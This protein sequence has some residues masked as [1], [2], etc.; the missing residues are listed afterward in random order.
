MYFKEFIQDKMEGKK[1]ILPALKE[2]AEINMTRVHIH[3][4]KSVYSN[5]IKIPKKNE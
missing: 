3:I 4:Y 1:K 5:F 2:E